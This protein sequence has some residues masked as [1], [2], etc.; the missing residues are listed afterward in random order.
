[1]EMFWSDDG[2]L[3]FQVHLK[4]GQRLQ[5]LNKGSNHQYST[6]D[7][8]PRGVFIRLARLTTITQDTKDMLIDER[9][10]L[11]AAALR[12]AGL[13][14]HDFPTLTQARQMDAEYW[15]D[16]QGSEAFDDSDADSADSA[17]NRHS[18]H[19]SARPRHLRQVWIQPILVGSTSC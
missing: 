18:F 19:F 5:Y 7:A 1:M 9:Y 3:H 16:A 10:P 15:K 17:P 13:F 2:S 11:H 8:I 6:F 12:K 4:M 14:D